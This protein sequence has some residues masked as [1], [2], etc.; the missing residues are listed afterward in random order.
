MKAY[1]A[2]AIRIIDE[3]DPFNDLRGGEMA[4]SWFEKLK[5]LHDSTEM[6]QAGEWGILYNGTKVGHADFGVVEQLVISI[7][8]HLG[9]GVQHLLHGKQ[10]EGMGYIHTAIDDCV[11]LAVEQARADFD[12][13]H[14]HREEIPFVSFREEIAVIEARI[15]TLMMFARLGANLAGQ[16]LA[17][18]VTADDMKAF[19]IAWVGQSK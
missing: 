8:G 18:A 19:A 9:L 6:P 5:K 10:S 17:L 13:E 1:V 11:K 7:V 15:K 16:Q 4:R 3:C 2:T 12:D 14:P